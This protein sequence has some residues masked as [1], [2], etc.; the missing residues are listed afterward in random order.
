VLARDGYDVT[1]IDPVARHVEQA[2]AAAQRA[3]VPVVSR[4]GDARRLDVED[5]APD[6]VLLLGPLYHLDAGGRRRALTEAARA[7]CPGGVLVAA[8]MAQ[9]GPNGFRLVVGFGESYVGAAGPEHIEEVPAVRDAAER[10]DGHA[11]GVVVAPQSGRERSD[12]GPM[13][14][15]LDEEHGARPGP[16]RSPLRPWP[17]PASPRVRSSV[18]RAACR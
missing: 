18:Q 13:A 4:L 6:A 10:D 17:L 9:L 16:P 5:G 1:L 7:L 3:S 2:H 12:R 15:A 14:R 8:A 11:I